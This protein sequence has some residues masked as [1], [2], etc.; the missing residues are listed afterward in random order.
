M[1]GRNSPVPQET[2]LKKGPGRLARR[3]VAQPVVREAAPPAPRSLRDA[4]GGRGASNKRQRANSRFANT[5]SISCLESL[6]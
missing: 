5:E 6:D 4:G 2:L 3:C 1:A